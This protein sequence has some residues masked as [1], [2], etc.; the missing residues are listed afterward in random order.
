VDSGDAGPE[1]KGT[2]GAADHWLVNDPV[3][4]SVTYH[5]AGHCQLQSFY[6]GEHEA[7]INVR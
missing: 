4:W 7:S 5:E 2:P 1:P 6:R 3:E